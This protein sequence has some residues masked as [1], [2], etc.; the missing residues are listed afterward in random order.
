[1]KNITPSNEEKGLLGIAGHA[2]IGH[3]FGS[4]DFMQEDSGAF[5]VLLHILERAYN[6]DFE[7]KSVRLVD[8]KTVE[9][10]TKS[11]GIG[12]GEAFRGFTPFDELIMKKSIGMKEL[13]PQSIATIIF[14]QIYGQGAGD[15]A[16]AFA[17]AFAKAL[18]DSIRKVCPTTLHSM[19]DNV[20]G[21]VGE[22]L[23]GVV[24]IE[25]IPVSWMLT[26]NASE[27][28]TGPNEDSEGTIPIGNKGIMMQCLGMNSI[29]L[30][31]LEGKA[32]FPHESSK[33]EKTCYYVRWNSEYDN[34]IVGNCLT[35]A[36]TCNQKI[37]VLNSNA[38]PR[39]TTTLDDAT[40][41]V[42]EEIVRIGQS[43]IN[44]QT[45]TEKISLMRELAYINSHIAGDSVFMSPAIEQI[46][47]AGGLWPGQGA[48]LSILA[49]K[50][51]VSEYRC[52]I[53]SL[54]EIFDFANIVV[55]ASIIL[56]KKIEESLPYIQ[57]RRPKLTPDQ[58]LALATPNNKN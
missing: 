13:A 21:S 25:G 53:L 50:K 17:L 56:A 34:P 42:G 58:I 5:A 31:V 51:E 41:D 36:L 57:S 7:I 29:P 23:G 14:G 2:G 45:A 24:N 3:A 19:P 54:A 9:V 55:D 4:D 26:I 22:F 35:E 18:I 44:A 12:L 16:S 30:I 10:T 33:L 11:G 32:Y 28:G 48:M 46:S 27:G 15:Q 20:P 8:S 6:P 47:G 1:M 40:R 39:M 49:D 43:Y 52:M 38:Y 37:F